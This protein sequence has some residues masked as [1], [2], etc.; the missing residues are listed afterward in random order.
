[1]KALLEFVGGL[2]ALVKLLLGAGGV[3]AFLRSCVALARE[4]AEMRMVWED[5]HERGQ[6]RER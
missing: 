6:H 3:V 4:Y 5:W 1:M 2:P